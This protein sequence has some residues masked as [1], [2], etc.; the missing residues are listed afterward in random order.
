MLTLEA[1]AK[2]NLT[3][4]VLGKRDDGYHEIVSVIQTVDLHDTVALES[5]D[6]IV[7]ECDRPE[8]ATPDNLAVRA[9]H[10]LR[11]RTG[12]AD[13]ARIV[14]DKRIPVAAGLGGGSSDAA[15]TFKGL[16]ELWG[17]GLSPGDLAEVAAELGSDVPFLLQG[18]AAML[19]SR[20]EV[21]RPLPP[22][23]LR[24]L[25]VLSPSIEL[26]DKTASLYGRVSEA[27]Y[28][29]G[30]LSRKLAA[31]IRGGGDVPPQF[32]FNTFDDVARE[33]F[34]GLD[35]YWAALHDLGA[36]EIHVT[37]T[38]PSLYAP[39]SR[40]EQGTAIQLMLRHRHGWEAHLVSPWQ[41]SEVGPQ[42]SSA[43]SPA[44]GEQTDRAG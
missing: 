2:I 22:P 33:A 35:A 24:W 28:T 20:G 25:V 15:A 5:A 9:A 4:E 38:G 29:P 37:G 44:S 27:N 18:G 30:H 42:A 7:L 1:H 8:L 34:P 16:N 19:E 43:M 32:L 36:R 40:K 31:R 26:S 21:M 23:D 6:G 3:L 17:L 11:E 10:L 39:V 41:P 12:C 13:G 14:L